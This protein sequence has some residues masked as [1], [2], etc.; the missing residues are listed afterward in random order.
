MLESDRNINDDP[1]PSPTLPTIQTL[2]PVSELID[3]QMSEEKLP[4]DDDKQPQEYKRIKVDET[5]YLPQGKIFIYV[6]L[7]FAFSL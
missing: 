6:L 3:E 7:Y 4:L 1:L 2:S 5:Y